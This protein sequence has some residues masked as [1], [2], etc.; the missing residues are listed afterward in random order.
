MNNINSTSNLGVAD[1]T[2]DTRLATHNMFN[3]LRH[4]AKTS[5]VG[6]LVAATL[7]AALYRHIEIHEGTEFA[8]K[9]NLA[10]AEVMLESVRPEL[11][12]YLASV[13]N[14]GPRE[15]AKDAFPP[16]LAMNIAGLMS[17]ASIRKVRI[18]NDLGVVSYSTERHEIGSVGT[19]NSELAATMSKGHAVSAVVYRD[20]F[21][22]FSPRSDDDNLLRTFVPVRLGPAES[23]R[24]ALVTYVDL[25]PVVA[26]QEREV[27]QVVGGIMSILMLLYGALLF[28]V[29]RA[30]KAIKA[31]QETIRERTATLERLSFQLLAGTEA[32]KMNLAANLHEGLAQRLSAIKSGIEC[33]M[34]RNSGTAASDDSLITSV[35]SLQSAIEEV[36]DM[37]TELRPSSLD[38][39]GLLP[40][41]RW[42]CREFEYLHPDIR[43]EQQ[44]SLQEQEIPVQL[45]IVIYRII[46]AVLKDIG[47]NAHRDRIRLRLEPNG[48]TI[49]LAIDDVPQDLTAAATTL[50]LKG[51]AHPQPRFAAAHERATL[52]GGAFSAAFN[53]EG[54]ITLNASWA[55]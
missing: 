15:I 34:E 16:S 51:T 19:G 41:I 45:K 28:V 10:L 36:Q 7:L 47:D 50:S 42:L 49:I 46:E 30:N 48:K 25:S 31:Q 11:G 8:N 44:V 52:S 26:Q 38:E 12:D 24:G 23:I 5:L 55:M 54:G 27:L 43:I 33:S 53:R 21:S 32:E 22:F 13:S 2:S 29:M 37:A 3:L 9:S 4:Y 1:S 40:T 39:L 18:Y 20:A 14:Q 6:M 17:K 35:E